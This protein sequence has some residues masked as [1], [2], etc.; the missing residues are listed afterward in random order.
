[1]THIVL[2]QQNYLKVIDSLHTIAD[3]ASQ[4]LT[5]LYKSQFPY[6]VHMHR[7]GKVRISVLYYIEAFMVIHSPQLCC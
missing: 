2:R 1:M 6:F 4:S 3:N 7:K 5:T